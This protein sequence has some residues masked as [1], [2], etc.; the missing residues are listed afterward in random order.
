MKSE[1]MKLQNLTVI[2]III[3]LPVV[4]VLSA[5]I[6]YEVQTIKKQ[7]MYNNGL[8]SATHDAIFAFELNTKNDIYYNNAESKRSNIKAAVKT[9]ENSL[10]N[11]CNLG[12]YNNEA[13]EEYIPAIVFGL[14]D[15]FYMYAPTQ[16]QNQGY[17][18]DLKNYVYYSE[19]INQ[20]NID[21]IIR[22]TLDN[23][24]AVSGTIGDK[25][26]TKAG[27][28]TNLDACNN[29]EYNLP[30]EADGKLGEATLESNFTYQ[31]A[32]IKSNETLHTYTYDQ[33]EKKV[34]LANVTNGEKE[35]DNSA[36]NY[37]KESIAFT[38]WFNKYIGSKA[39][40]L[41]IKDGNDPEDENSLF[42]Q[43]KR[44][45]MKEKIQSILNSSI[46]AYSNK[47]RNNYKMPVL[48]EEDWDKIY[49]NISVISF[50]QGIN[51]GFKNYNNYCIL[52]STNNQ[53]YVNPNLIY[54]SDNNNY[55]DIRCDEIKENSTTGYK[56][57]DFEK[58]KYEITNNEEQVVDTAYYYKHNELACYKC[59]NGSLNN[60]KIIYDYV[61]S[62]DTK[63]E[64]KTSYFTSLARERY[65]TTKLLSSYNK[66]DKIELKL[67]FD[68]NTESVVD[69]M[70]DPPTRTVYKGDPI[71]LSDLPEPTKTGYDFVGWNEDKNSETGTK[72]FEG[73]LILKDTTLYAIWAKK[74]EI[75]FNT[76]G[77]T[78]ISSIHVTANNTVQRPQ[79]PEKE[80]FEFINWYT[81]SACTK[82]YEF[83]TP[84]NSNI[85]LYAKWKKNSITVKYSYDG[86]VWT[87][88][89]VT[90]SGTYTVKDVSSANKSGYILV[91]W[92][93][94]GTTYE[95]GSII[96]YD[97]NN[98][99]EIELKV[100]YI[101]DFEITI[102]AYDQNNS[103]ILNY[104][105]K[106]LAE[107][108]NSKETDTN[109][110]TNATK[111]KVIPK[112]SIDSAKI[113][114][115]IS[116]GFSSGQED[117][118][119][120]TVAVIPV[121]D[122]IKLSEKQKQQVIV[123]DKTPPEWEKCKIA[124]IK[125]LTRSQLYVKA[126]DNLSGIREIRLKFDVGYISMELNPKTS[127]EYS[128]DNYN[129]YGGIHLGVEGYS[130]NDCK[131]H[132]ITIT[133]KAG[134]SFG[135]IQHNH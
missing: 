73:Y 96:T 103:K 125:S 58:I 69:D 116:D 20:G 32:H 51:L 11:T 21:I 56:I 134:N 123:I 111:V 113:K 38:S 119:W 25:Y 108:K 31:G 88:K 55:H 79:D 17:K 43:H 94:E 77:G 106:C 80:G 42:V 8:V 98:T 95:N 118:G 78:P 28:L 54:F 85:T 47:T 89:N 37:F 5:Y 135:P 107:D 1:Y 102:T 39:T 59:I 22:Y 127:G 104:K 62:N 87:D 64:V 129:Y 33:N 97:Q 131:R 82:L 130:N 40:H 67:T 30:K 27:Y 83:S 35:V 50:V 18:H 52:N 74:Y 117:E 72:K 99:Q 12:L 75:N 121:V 7:N 16:T 70:P 91:G 109:I 86:N 76:Q 128:K 34:V 63:P 10:S 90:N 13:I 61:R 105:E 84:V 49:N 68:K 44:K 114:Y 65:K 124:A 48:N 23:Y 81:D 4:L 53:E 15:G 3:I 57:G 41:D 132:K 9:F 66:L 126:S 110:Y 92:K 60:E 112:L 26:I 2:F 6:G 19:E 71:N 14:Y 36:I 122:G 45:I 120:Y 93:Y 100:N 101:Q 29:F 115:E 24:V 46:T 133:D